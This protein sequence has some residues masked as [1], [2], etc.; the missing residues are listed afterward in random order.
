M[1]MYLIRCIFF[2]C[3]CC[4]LSACVPTNSIRPG[5]VSLKESSADIFQDITLDKSYLLDSNDVVKVAVWEHA[6]LDAEAQVDGAGYLSLPLIGKVKAAG[7]SVDDIQK[8]I[9]EKLKKYYR[10]PHVL[11][12]L[13][14]MASRICYV[15][16]EVKT[17]GSYMMEHNM[18]LIDVLMKAGGPTDDAGD[19]ILL[20]RR[21]GDKLRIITATIDMN[22]L[23]AGNVDLL[24]VVLRKGDVVYVAAS[25]MAQ[26]DKA[27]QRL[28]N[29]LNPLLNI[30][31]GVILWP[32][33]V[34]AM[35][36]ERPDISVQ[37]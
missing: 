5:S 1:Y 14:K 36:D 3:F 24:R 22:D 37:L 33:L 20:L 17:S 29:I 2:L 35:Q 7:S 13:N 4:C 26:L 28:N 19:R 12:T 15:L 32:D 16:G 10:D 27:M 23:A 8:E 9:S 30:E 31:R 6:S 25:S 21:E 34:N 18:H 11:V